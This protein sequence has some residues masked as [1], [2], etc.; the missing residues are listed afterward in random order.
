MC[1]VEAHSSLFPLRRVIASAARNPS[2]RAK[3]SVPAK[4]VLFFRR[5]MRDDDDVDDDDD[6]DGDGGGVSNELTG[7]CFQTEEQR[8]SFKTKGYKKKKKKKSTRK[9]ER[10][11]RRD[12]D[13]YQ[14]K[15]L[16]RYQ[17]ECKPVDAK[18]PNKI[19]QSP[20]STGTIAVGTWK[21]KLDTLL[22]LKGVG[23]LHTNQMSATFFESRF[24]MRNTQI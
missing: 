22:F 14:R 23:A 8:E 12:L 5:C 19:P 15:R 17:N 3:L 10:D 13:K 24:Y 18:N 9:S 21:K 2:L 16:F 20:L 4:R 6:D 11:G 1:D 7:F